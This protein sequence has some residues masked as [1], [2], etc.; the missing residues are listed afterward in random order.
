MIPPKPG[1]FG[2]RELHAG[3]RETAFA[4]Y[5]GL[6]GWTKA[7]TFDMGPMGSINCSTSTARWRAA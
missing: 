1:H 6:F 3:D 7:D 5:S 4:F 2:W